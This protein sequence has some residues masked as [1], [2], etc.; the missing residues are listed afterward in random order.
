MGTAEWLEEVYELI[1]NSE[2]ENKGMLLIRWA[3]IAT[4]L[5]YEIEFRDDQ[6]DF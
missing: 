1:N 2:T 5:G 3:T 6:T 4:K